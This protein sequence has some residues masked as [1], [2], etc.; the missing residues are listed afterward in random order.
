MSASILE[1]IEAHQ[2]QILK[3]QGEIAA[4]IGGLVARL[5]EHD[6]RLGDL[7]DRQALHGRRFRLLLWL[8]PVACAISALAGAWV[9]LRL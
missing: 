3:G 1:R 4:T 7:E 6:A 8:F 5:N 9:A 2:I